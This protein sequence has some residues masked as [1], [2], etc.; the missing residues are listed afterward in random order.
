MKLE[1]ISLR[2]FE[3]F[4]Q[5][6]VWQLICQTMQDRIQIVRSEIACGL[7][8]ELEEIRIK[9]GEN[10]AYIEVIDLPDVWIEILTK[11]EESKNG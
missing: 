10:K 2:E 3:E 9:Q 8:L 1:D 6:P 11:P 7:Q 5:N 4:K